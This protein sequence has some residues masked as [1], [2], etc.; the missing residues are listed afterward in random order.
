M[1]A[2]KHCNRGVLKDIM[3]GQKLVSIAPILERITWILIVGGRKSTTT[4]SRISWMVSVSG[5]TNFELC[6]SW[7]FF[8]KLMT[9]LHNGRRLLKARA[10]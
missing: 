2:S 10:G 4:K 1:P 3:R 8:A 6:G 9:G 5:V 7:S